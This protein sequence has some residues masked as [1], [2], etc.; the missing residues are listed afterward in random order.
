M[1]LKKRIY[2]TSYEFFVQTNL[3]VCSLTDMV[4]LVIMSNGQKKVLNHQENTHA[5]Y[6]F[7]KLIGK[8]VNR[9]L[10]NTVNSQLE[11]TA[12]NLLS[13]MGL[14]KKSRAVKRRQKIKFVFRSW[15]LAELYK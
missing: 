12:G 11:V 10:N 4:S 13:C 1:L 6:I 2:Q 14:L 15:A 7:G 8:M 3:S 5:K 9:Y